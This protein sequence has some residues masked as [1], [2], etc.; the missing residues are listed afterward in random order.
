MGK[1]TKNVI[2]KIEEKYKLLL[3][4]ISRKHIKKY[5]IKNNTMKIN[6]LVSFVFNSISLI[7]LLHRNKSPEANINLYKDSLFQFVSKLH[8]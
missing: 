5:N 3:D 2:T 1:K 7:S 4:K 6:Q 8:N